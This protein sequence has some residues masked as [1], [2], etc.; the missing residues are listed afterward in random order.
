[1][2]P[3]ARGVAGLTKPSPMQH[4]IVSAHHHVAH[5]RQITINSKNQ[6]NIVDR[7][8]RRR[9]GNRCALLEIAHKIEY[10]PEKGHEQ[11]VNSRKLRRAP[12]K[13][14][15]N[16]ATL[17]AFHHFWC[18][19]TPTKIEPQNHHDRHWRGPAAPAAAKFF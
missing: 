6:V 4:G 13:K 12:H 15:R 5:V 17:G 3:F 19:F 16:T 1:M 11:C 14:E 18:V 7:A 9:E 8:G 10:R 2:N